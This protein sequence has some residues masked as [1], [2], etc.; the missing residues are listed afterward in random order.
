MVSRRRRTQHPLC[1]RLV[2]LIEDHPISAETVVLWQVKEEA[3]QAKYDTSSHQRHLLHE[4]LELGLEAL[5]VLGLLTFVVDRQK[6]KL[7]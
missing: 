1:R 6:S 5:K 4:R 3:N 7:A 2:L